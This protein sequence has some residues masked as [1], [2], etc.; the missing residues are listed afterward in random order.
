YFSRQRILGTDWTGSAYVAQLGL[1]LGDRWRLNSSYQWSPNSRAV[2]VATF[3][4]QRRLGTAGVVNIAYHYRRGRLEQYS[5]SA[6][7]PLSDRWR[8]FGAWAFAPAIKSP[9][10]LPAGTVDALFGVEYDSCCVT[11]RL[12]DRNYV[13][14]SYYGTA[15]PPTGSNI[16]R[17]DNAVMFEVVFKGLGSTGGQIDPLLRRDIL[18]YQ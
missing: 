14:Q 3:G 18:G 4:L 6:V 8:L 15:K 2:E 16:G 7:Y 1:Q 12:V 17:R 5:A 11:L 13:N 10:P 9:Y